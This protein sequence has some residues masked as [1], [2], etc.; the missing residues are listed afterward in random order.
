MVSEKKNIVYWGQRGKSEGI[1][2]IRNQGR[3]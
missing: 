1:I 3:L 2:G